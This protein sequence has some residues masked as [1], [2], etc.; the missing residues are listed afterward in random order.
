MYMSANI[1]VQLHTNLELVYF[2]KFSP[3]WFS[4]KCFPLI[5]YERTIEKKAM[6]CFKLGLS[7][8]I[9]K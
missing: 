7:R 2:G 1:K 8:G 3:S 4:E 9:L 5:V 6:L